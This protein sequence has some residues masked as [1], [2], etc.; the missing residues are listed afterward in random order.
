MKRIAEILRGPY[1]ITLLMVLIFGSFL[2]FNTWSFSVKLLQS[3]YSH[4][5]IFIFGLALLITLI[6][7]FVLRTEARFF[8]VLLT[9]FVSDLVFFQSKLFF[10]RAKP[11]LYFVMVYL[12][13]ASFYT[14]ICLGALKQWFRIIVEKLKQVSLLRRPLIRFLIYLL[15]GGILFGLFIL[16]SA[17]STDKYILIFLLALLFIASVFFDILIR[18]LIK[19]SDRLKIGYLRKPLFLLFIY[20]ISLAALVVILKPKV[21]GLITEFY[22]RYWMPIVL[23]SPVIVM[24][25]KKVKKNKKENY[26]TGV[27]VYFFGYVI[28][29]LINRWLKSNLA[30]NLAVSAILYLGTIIY[31]YFTEIGTNL[32][33]IIAKLLLVIKEKIIPRVVGTKNTLVSV[34][35]AVRTKSSSVGQ[36]IFPKIIAHRGKII[37]FLVLIAL[38][39]AGLKIASVV[40]RQFYVTVMEFSPQGEVPPKTIIRLTFSKPVKLTVDDISKLDCFNITPPIEGE[41]RIEG[42][43]TIVFIPREELKPSTLYQV[44]L[45]SKNL[46]SFK[47]K[48]TS[49]DKIE[50]HTELFKVADVRMFYLYDLANNEEKMIMGEINFNYPVELERLKEKVEVFCELKPVEIEFEKS[51]VPT[52]FYFKTGLVQRAKKKQTIRFI[53]RKDLACINGTTPLTREVERI[54]S[55]PAKMKFQVSQIKLW[56]EPGNTMITI[57]FNMPVSKEQVSKFVSIKP[58][59]PVTIETEYCYA[60]LRGDF[61]PNIE[62]SVTVNQGLLSKSGEILEEK[63]VQSIVI[64]DLPPKVEFAHNGRILPLEGEMNIAVKTMNLDNV[65][66]TIR[67]IF[68]NNLIQF[69]NSGESPNYNISSEVYSGSY[70]V[71]GGQINEELLQYINLRKFHHAPYKGLFSV[72][73]QARGVNNNSY[74]RD[75]GEEGEYEGEGEY[76]GY[77]THGQTRR[78]FLCTEI[79]L[80]AKKSGDDLIVYALSLKDLSPKPN[81]KVKLISQS[82][83]VIDEGLTGE[84]G[85]IIFI[86]WEKNSFGFNPYVLVAEKDDDFSFLKFNS[87]MLNQHQFQIGG[88]PYSDKGMEAFLSP[89]RGVYRPGEKAY[90][91]AIVRNKDFSTPPVLPARII[92]QDPQGGEFARFEKK[93]NDNG[94]MSFEV[95]F[96]TQSLTGEYQITLVRID[97][98][99]TIGRTSVKVEEFIPD[100]LKVEVVP[101]RETMEAG[102][103]L[104]FSVIGKQ[105]FGPPAAGNKV[106]TVVQFLPRIFSHPNF[107]EYKFSD[108]SRSFEEETQRLGEAVLDATGTK[109]YEVG[110]PR[111]KPPS[112]LLAYIYAE[113]YD[114]GGR[115]VSAVTTVPIN[116]YPYYLGIK[117]QKEPF[118]KTGQEIK[119]DY[120]AINSQGK[121]QD[122]KN[123]QLLVKRKIWYSIFRQGSWG[124]SGFQSSTYEEVVIQKVVNIRGKGE[125]SFVPEMAGEY[126]IY[127]GNEDGMRTGMVLNVVGTGYQAWGLES[128]EK[129]EISLDKKVYDA[130]DNAVINI[131]APFTGKLFLSIEREK[132][133]YTEI[134]ELKEKTVQINIPVKSEYL[135][136]V[137]V[138][139]MLV[140][141]P[142]N[143]NE[144]FPMVSFGIVPLEVNKSPQKISITP[145]CKDKVD[146]KD[147][148]DVTVKLDNFEPKTNVVLIAVDQG[149]LQITN[150]QTPDPLQFFYRKNSLTTQTYSI[151][152][153][154]LPDIKTKMFA[155][156]GD[157]GEFTRRHL[158]PVAAKRPKSLAQ[159]SGILTPDQNGEVKYH[160][161]TSNFNGEVRVM[162]LAV[163]GDKF[164]SIAKQVTV[165]DPIVLVPNFPRFLG[166][167]D[168]FEIPVQVYNNTGKSG[169]F[170]IAIEASGPVDLSGDKEKKVFLRHKAENKLVFTA[171]AR[172]DAGVAKFKVIARG[173]DKEAVNQAEVSVRPYT[174]LESTVKLGELNSEQSVK[175]NIPAGFIPY[176]QRIRFTLSSNPL[177]QYLQSL[178]Y[179]ITYPYGCI[180]QITSKIF[181]LLYFKELGYATGMFAEKANAVDLFVQEGIG[182]IE[183]MQLS[184]GTFALWPGGSFCGRW[185]NL[186]VCHFLIE[187]QKMGYKI[188][189]EM[190]SKVLSYLNSLNVIPQAQGRL[191]RR[192]QNLPREIDVYALYVKTLSGSLDKEL[193]AFLLQNKLNSLG[194]VDR[195]LLSLCYSEIGDKATALRVLKPDFKSLFQYREQY[196][197]FNSPIRNTAMYLLA[198]ASSETPTS[199]KI[200]EIIRYL[201]ENMRDGHF[202]NTQEDAWVFI[203]LGKAVQA[204]EHGINVQM[205]VDEK[206]YKTITGKTEI[207]SD[208]H[209]SGKKVELKNIS[210]KKCYYHLIAEGTPLE[211]HQ[212][213]NFNGL[214]ITRKYLDEN[215]KP[216]NLS[217]VVQ[218]QMVIATINVKS[219]REAIHNLVIVDL[220][221]AG[222]EVENPRLA[223]R[224]NIRFQPEIS[225]Y[226]IYQDIRDDRLLI[227]LD[228]LSGSQ[229]FSYVLRAVTPGRFTIPNIYGEAMYDP[230]IKGEEFEK[231]YLV[232]VPSN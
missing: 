191:D 80:M 124:R 212:S 177:I 204:L 34:A 171:Q 114:S 155:V 133:Y 1:F 142:G 76:Y 182:K 217:S 43:R 232:I 131:R 220:L 81:T 231:N 166:P 40:A 116:N 53:V 69:L 59:I 215:G 139:G 140:R 218:G 172:Y 156:G 99:E 60:V 24:L 41:Y 173:V 134:V 164:G 168:Q 144:N 33:Q 205:N 106:N 75:Y 111:L 82:N 118:Y 6:R 113:V 160:F 223:S 10:V 48:I 15:F 100:K 180:E 148:I 13:A 52:R 98:D 25:F 35:S 153:M 161:N 46:K 119:I 26:F 51:Y 129:L 7:K 39:I 17:A 150:F 219:Q 63:R 214:E 179:L 137:Y 71:K 65:Q 222:F 107:G 31:F 44:R 54:L 221:P 209:L 78:W 197:S 186:Y 132:V 141:Q 28:F 178:E 122:I 145:I 38:V 56:H 94:M 90:I 22:N 70:T 67:K 68:R 193:M 30:E 3:F 64:T 224:G 49:G 216:L 84:D 226:P 29:R 194:E 57:L 74:E 23:L 165:V 198:L 108:P 169:N 12:F 89:E 95:N 128:P 92:V 175:I 229:S 50:F 195:A 110:V 188:N 109:K 157:Y 47:K 88:T 181:P 192:S 227:F 127:L 86:N 151:M 121:L 162:A 42:E 27:I 208:S 72:E 102:N 61:K 189:P 117:V 9:F 146:S 83:Q 101:E 135:P 203:S 167:G 199:A 225:L 126:Y 97:K 158:N 123:V 11:T 104:V 45:N 207:V 21:S 206:P 196:G 213:N 187:A 37:I 154:I 93:W 77:T 79:G 19:L 112:A 14:G 210:D 152:D 32:S 228:Q 55:L 149:I 147:G 91:T 85:K 5:W 190:M 18:L 8:T 103:L 62:Y 105:M 58:Q 136:N 96:P 201:G 120:V 36:V 174:H 115:A 185:L 125:F 159:Y 170:T 73:L 130:G 211:K 202:G 143:G 230:D 87:S 200:N 138:T 176:G 16:V 184:D 183:D 66:V 4:W 2:K 163:S 20:L